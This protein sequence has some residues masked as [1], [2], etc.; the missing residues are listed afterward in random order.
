MTD[1]GGRL[2]LSGGSYMMSIAIVLGSAFG[3][4]LGLGRA[5]GRTPRPLTEDTHTLLT[6]PP[7]PL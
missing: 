2:R 6:S 7:S 1:K 5:L 3:F 4:G